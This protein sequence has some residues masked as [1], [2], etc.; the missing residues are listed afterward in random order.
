ME[1]LGGW[2]AACVYGLKGFVMELSGPAML[3]TLPR[4]KKNELQIDSKQGK[5]NGRG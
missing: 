2:T 3:F 5:W 1:A 4:L